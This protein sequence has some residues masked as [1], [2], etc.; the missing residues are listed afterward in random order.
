[1]TRHPIGAE[2]FFYRVNSGEF[3]ED[4][5]LSP[6]TEREKADEIPDCDGDAALYDDFSSGENG[7]CTSRNYF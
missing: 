3:A 1:M 6:Q 4:F 5:D 7:F 2:G